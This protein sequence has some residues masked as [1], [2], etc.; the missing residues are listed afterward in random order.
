MKYD[1]RDVIYILHVDFTGISIPHG[2]FNE[3]TILKLAS[4]L[5]TCIR[6]KLISYDEKK[7]MLNQ[8]HLLLLSPNA[9]P[10]NVPLIFNS[11]AMQ[12]I[13]V[14][15]LRVNGNQAIQEVNFVFVSFFHF[16]LN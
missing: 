13:S 11:S 6:I 12:D 10:V 4:L 14:C 2:S 5:A 7:W 8:L 9:P 15:K 16:I 1:M 3:L